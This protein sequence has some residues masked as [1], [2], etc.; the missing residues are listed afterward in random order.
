M[1]TSCLGLHAEGKLECVCVCACVCFVFR[2]MWEG[3]RLI[4]HSVGG[5]W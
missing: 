2:C 3:D 4:S 1:P 5:F